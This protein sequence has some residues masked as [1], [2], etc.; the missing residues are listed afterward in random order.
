MLIIDRDFIGGERCPRRDWAMPRVTGALGHFGQE[1]VRYLP[2]GPHIDIWPGCVA[3]QEWSGR[4]T[5]R[6]VPR[7]MV[8]PVAVDAKGTRQGTELGLS[9]AC[10][11]RI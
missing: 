9:G 6:P 11:G 8:H 1:T 5:S 10:D 2:N 3:G 7:Q 4:H